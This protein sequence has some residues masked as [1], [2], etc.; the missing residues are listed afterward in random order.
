MIKNEIFSRNMFGNVVTFVHLVMNPEDKKK[1]LQKRHADGSDSEM[2]LKAMEVIK[3][4]LPLISCN[5]MITDH[6]LLKKPL[7]LRRTRRSLAW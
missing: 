1:R 5:S 4:P 2:M 6:R 7:T 3:L